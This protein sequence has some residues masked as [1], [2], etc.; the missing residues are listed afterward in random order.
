MVMRAAASRTAVCMLAHLD[1]MRAAFS[2]TGWGVATPSTL[3]VG[4]YIS[5]LSKDVPV[6]QATEGSM[7]PSSVA[8]EP[9][10]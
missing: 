2:H 10:W 1:K 5:G 6:A 7:L 9:A 4:D 3:T 8:K